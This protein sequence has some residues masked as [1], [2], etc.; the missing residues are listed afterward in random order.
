ML[1]VGPHSTGRAFRFPEQ[2]QMGKKETHAVIFDMDGVLVDS[3]IAIVENTSILLASCGMQVPRSDVLRAV[4]N[5]NSAATILTG[6]VPSLAQ[7]KEK[8]GQMVLELA[9][10]TEVNIDAIKPTAISEKL[11]ELTEK[12][13]LGIATN[14]VKS[15]AHAILESLGIGKFFKS[16][17]TLADALPKPNPQMPLLALS[18]LGV[19]APRVVFVGDKESDREAGMRA[20]VR[21]IIVDATKGKEGCEP[22]LREF[23]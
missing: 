16:V 7:D 9:K 15:T 6:A 2:P 5:G 13:P 17:I 8:L 18:N 14:R 1:F 20:G 4:E 12:Y 19:P 23:G 3:K 21:T 22:F 11:P 10:I